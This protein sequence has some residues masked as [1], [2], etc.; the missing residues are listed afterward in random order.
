MS[1]GGG[2]P[3][4]ISQF[5]MDC[6]LPL[7][8]DMDTSRESLRT[9]TTENQSSMDLSRTFWDADDWLSKISDEDLETASLIS[10][11]TTERMPGPA[12]RSRNWCF[13][14]NNPHQCAL[15]NTR[16]E[17]L[18]TSSEDPSEKPSSDQSLFVSSGP[19]YLDCSKSPYPIKLCVWQAERGSGGTLHLQGYIEMGSPQ[20]LSTMRSLL[21]G[22][23]HLE[24]RLGSQQQAVKYVTKAEHGLSSEDLDIFGLD[25]PWVYPAHKKQDILDRAY[26][27]ENVLT[28]KNKNEK[29]FDLMWKDVKSGYSNIDLADKYG[30][31]FARH[32]KWIQSIRVDLTPPRNWAMN[33]IVIQG[34]SGVG[35]SRWA[36]D[37]FGYEKVYPKSN[38]QWWCFYDRHETVLMDDFYAWCCWSDFLR[39]SD[40][41]PMLVPIKGAQ[42]QLVAKNLI[43]TTNTIPCKWYPNCQYEAFARRVSKYLVWNDVNNSF[44]TF[45]NSDSTNA[46]DAMRVY[47]QAYNSMKDYHKRDKQ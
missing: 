43:I 27:D 24:K 20:R 5:A 12:Q 40:R 35:K 13:T 3:S 38:D 39:F 9:E 16:E 18:N 31:L 45:D 6:E 23:A 37:N 14:L 26:A 47:L 19:P 4:L 46:T 1:W 7:L 17:V 41:Y 28:Q 21:G 30:S 36:Y 29:K 32:F 22:K 8:D 2:N 15:R 10:N 34:P 42:A 44:D 11:F 25:M 33:V